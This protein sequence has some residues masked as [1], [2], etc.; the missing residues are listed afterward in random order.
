[1]V[2]QLLAL[3]R[4]R[5]RARTRARAWASQSWPAIENLEERT[6]LSSATLAILNGNFTGTYS[7]TIT[8]NNNGSITKT[9]VTSTAFTMTTNNGAVTF[10]TP[11]CST[12]LAA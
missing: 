6:L 9:P 7:G 1:M 2:P 11:G 10:T 8:V 3:L 5:P 4:S 12:R